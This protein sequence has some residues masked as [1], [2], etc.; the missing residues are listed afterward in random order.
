MIRLIFLC[1]LWISPF[2]HAE[3]HAKAITDKGGVRGTPV[4]DYT[5]SPRVSP[6]VWEMVKPYLLPSNHPIKPALDRIFSQTRVTA[7]AKSVKR[8]GFKKP[9]PRPYSH[10]T[11]SHHPSLKGYLVKLFTDD[12]PLLCDHLAWIKRI[13]GANAVQ[14]SID[15]HKF[16]HFFKVPGKWIYP[17]PANP[18]PRNINKGKNFIL[19]VEDMDIYEKQKNYDR[20]RGKKMTPQRIDAVWIVMEENGLSDSIRPFNIPFCKDGLQAFID[21]EH[22]H[23]WPV[24]Y[25]IMARYL[26]SSI[27]QHWIEL[28]R[29]GGPKS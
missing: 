8:A 27:E 23:E 25:E 19:V 9:L 29:R 26:S 20:W 7:N 13:K 15:K 2:I 21:T 17:L 6:E 12:Q 16:H 3:G 18:P 5:P 1:L 22:H 10:C 14:K 11:V 4:F 28:M 24:H